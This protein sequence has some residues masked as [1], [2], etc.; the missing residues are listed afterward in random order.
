[1]FGAHG[2]GLRRGGCHPAD[3]GANLD[4][5][6][7]MDACLSPTRRYVNIVWKFFTLDDS[8]LMELAAA[9]VQAHFVEAVQF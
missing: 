8:P 2:E 5:K 7:V 1:M 3:G 9:Q 4:G 6:L